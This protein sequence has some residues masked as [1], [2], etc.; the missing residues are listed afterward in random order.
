MM[1]GMS[2]SCQI[3]GKHLSFGNTV[4]HSHIRTRRRFLPNLH[5]K[6]YWAPSLQRHVT[7]MVSVKGMRTIDRRG[8][9]AI[10]Q[11]LAARGEL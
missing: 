4:S 6:R 8:I 11:E 10:V 5:R 9:D 7:L 2:K 1:A 3:L